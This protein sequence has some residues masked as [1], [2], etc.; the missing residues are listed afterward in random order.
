M[1]KPLGFQVLLS[2]DH[3]GSN[4][5]V[6]NGDLFAFLNSTMGTN[7]ELLPFREDVSIRI[8]RMIEQRY[9]NVE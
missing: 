6:G 2:H 1:K 9:K 4:T 5:C 8:T 7:S 3:V